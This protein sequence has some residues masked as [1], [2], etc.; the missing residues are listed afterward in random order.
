ML[1]TLDECDASPIEAARRIIAAHQWIFAKT[2]PWVPHEY[3]RRSDCK[4]AKVFEW[5]V[6][7]IRDVGRLERYG[8]SIRSYLHLD[9]YKYWTMGAP[10]METIII[11]RQATDRG[12]TNTSVPL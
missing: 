4:D 2:M 12:Y 1:P 11:N 5:F 10:V 7:Y 9:N 8:K 3:I 6:Q